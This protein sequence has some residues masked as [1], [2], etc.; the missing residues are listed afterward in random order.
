M[1]LKSVALTIVRH[2]FKKHV[3]YTLKKYSKDMVVKT[4]FKTGKEKCVEL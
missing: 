3:Y 2:N 1:L 4:K